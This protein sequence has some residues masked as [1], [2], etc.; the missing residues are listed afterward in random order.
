MKTIS[1]RELHQATGRYV[2]ETRTQ[3]LLV[4]ERG[5]PVALLKPYAA[6]ELP[7]RAFPKRNPRDLPR[8]DHDS[9][10]SIAQDRDAR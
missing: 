1:I 2:R 3:T 9:T 4:T 6:H 7:G 8:A 10:L 5:H